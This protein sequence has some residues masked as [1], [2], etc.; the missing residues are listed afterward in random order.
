MATFAAT[1]NS[2]IE[3]FSGGAGGFSST[4]GQTFALSK[5]PRLAGDVDGDGKVDFLML[6]TVGAQLTVQL[7]FGGSWITLGLGN[8]D[9]VLQAASGFGDADG[10]G[11]ADVALASSTAQTL[12]LYSGATLRQRQTQTA[13]TIADPGLIGTLIFLAGLQ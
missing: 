6:Q 8:A 13:A 2:G 7:V 5:Q 3:I 10:D 9:T 12:S 1:A 11:Y 4:P